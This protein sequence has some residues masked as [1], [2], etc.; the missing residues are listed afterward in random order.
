MVTPISREQ[1][2]EKQKQGTLSR[3]EKV[4]YLIQVRGM[5]RSD[6]DYIVDAKYKQEIQLRAK[7]EQEIS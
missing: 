1:L 5:L 6:A 3:E 2:L 7:G 4:E